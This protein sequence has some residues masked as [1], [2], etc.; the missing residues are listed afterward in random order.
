M[1][2]AHKP[3]VPA[4]LAFLVVLFGIGALEP[5]QA[6]STGKWKK[7]QLSLVEGMFHYKEKKT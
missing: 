2:F 5:A 6:Q 4:V 3:A 7:Q 1:G